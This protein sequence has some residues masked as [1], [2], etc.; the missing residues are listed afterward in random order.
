LRH[1]LKGHRYFLRI[2]NDPESLANLFYVGI[3]LAI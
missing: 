1:C 3:N 2:N